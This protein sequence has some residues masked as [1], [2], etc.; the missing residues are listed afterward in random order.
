MRRWMFLVL[1]AVLGCLTAVI[2]IFPAKSPDAHVGL[3]GEWRFALDAMDAGVK[4]Q[5]F[6][7]TLSD[8]IRLPGVLQAQ[9]HGNEISTQ[10]PWVL[11]LYDRFWYLREE[12][13]PYAKAG[14]VRVPFLSQP[15][16]HYLGAAWYQ[17]EIEIPPD[18]QGRRVALRLERPHWETSIWVDDREVGSNRS[19]VAPHLHDLAALAPGQHKLTIRVDNRMILPYRPDAHSVS[20]SLGSSWN[21]IAGTIELASTS[22]VWIDN[23]QAF[24]NVDKKSVLVKLW[25][26]NIT[27]RA[28]M[29]VL[30]TGDMSVPLKWDAAGGRADIE[31]SLAKDAQLWDE[32]NPALQHLTLQLKGEQANDQRELTFGLRGLKAE[33]NRFVLN[34]KPIVF[35]GTHHGGD[36]PLTGFPP[37]D[38]EYWKR[39][40][41]ICQAWGLNHMRFHSWCPPDAAFVAADELGFYFQ[42]EAGMWNEISP[43]SEMEKMMYE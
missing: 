29:G 1:P 3:A 6:L 33:G 21:G 39:I 43:G 34:G 11:S 15:P 37:T 13:K 38:V 36:F 31:V 16:R 17:R 32:F 9:G 14:T 42:P 19:L 20:D 28:G 27:G 5:W 10:T 4:E 35:R 30:S 12:Y 2:Q 40:I 24:P 8:H 41:R 23:A 25:I 26:G 18:W 22:P 7:K